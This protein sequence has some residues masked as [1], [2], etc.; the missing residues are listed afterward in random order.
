M[1][2]LATISWGEIAW[3]LP[4]M[5][6]VFCL[7]YYHAKDLDILQMGAESAQSIGVNTQRTTHVVLIASSILIGVVVSFCGV[8]GFIG[9]IVPNIVRILFGSGNRRLFTYAILFG[10]FFLLAA[11]TLARTIAA[12]SELP[13]GSITALA[14]APYFIYLLI[15][16]KPSAKQ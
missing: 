1:G 2:S 3:M 8:I 16:N 6:V 12:P 5:L 7:L 11:D 15:R 9:L 13:V 4:V 14:G 10:A